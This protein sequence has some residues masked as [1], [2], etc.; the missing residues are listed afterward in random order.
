MSR[1]LDTTTVQKP[2]RFA[3]VVLLV[4]DL[5]ASTDWYVRFVGMDV[6]F[7]S[8]GI[9]FLTYDGEHHRLA[10]IKAGQTGRAA[11]GSPGLDHFAYTMPDLGAL[12]GSWERLKALG[13][14]PYFCVNHG[15]T[16]SLYYHDP[17]GNG[18]E[19]QIDNFESAEEAYAWMHTEAFQK[20]P[21][22]VEF[23]PED[24]AERYEQGE[25]LA[26]LLVRGDA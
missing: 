24:L 3:H 20:N 1:S 12:L 25:A 13:I 15:P 11:P 8:E 26:T 4:S 7:R 18:V 22:G 19:L 5:D 10:L 9:A 2:T 14:L 6:V 23:D 17:D 16:T 21:I